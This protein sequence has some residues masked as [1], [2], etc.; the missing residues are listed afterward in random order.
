MGLHKLKRR[1][2]SSDDRLKDMYM[3]LI[4]FGGLYQSLHLMHPDSYTGLNIDV[5]DLRALFRYRGYCI[6]LIKTRR[7]P[8]LF[9]DLKN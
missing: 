3:G 5:H 4:T 9:L 6:R 2:Q 1:V 8:V 7:L